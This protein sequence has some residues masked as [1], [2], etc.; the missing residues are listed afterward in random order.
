MSSDI[1]RRYVVA[2]DVSSDWRR[3]RIAHALEGHG[4]R[5]Q[6]SVFLVDA[7]PSRLI[8]L[9]SKLLEYLDL[10]TDSVLICDLG[11]LEQGASKRMTTI[12]VERTYLGQGPIV[13]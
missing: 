3:T 6:F 2:Y 8:R 5:I 1:T 13:L 11:P 10:A 7:K 12:G 4:D 9:R